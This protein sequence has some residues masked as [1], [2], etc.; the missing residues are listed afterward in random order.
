MS[1]QEL[2]V[3]GVVQGYLEFSGCCHAEK[4]PFLDR[5]VIYFFTSKFVTTKPSFPH[6]K[7]IHKWYLLP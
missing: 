6:A 4:P 7:W 5:A 1:E 2:K 3:L